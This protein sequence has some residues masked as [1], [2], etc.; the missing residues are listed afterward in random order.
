[1]LRDPVVMHDADDLFL[2]GAVTGIQMHQRIEKDVPSLNPCKLEDSPDNWHA[3]MSCIFLCLPLL[4]LMN[5]QH[6]QIGK[7]EYC[8]ILQSLY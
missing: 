2:S 1:M 4:Q 6:M 3:S 8:N 7:T 5:T